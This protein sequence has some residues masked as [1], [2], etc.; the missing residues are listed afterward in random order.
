MKTMRFF[1]FVAHDNEFVLG[2]GESL[3]AMLKKVM[4]ADF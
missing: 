3:D 2:D 4:G 1:D